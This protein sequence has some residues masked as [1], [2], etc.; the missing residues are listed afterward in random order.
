[1]RTWYFKRP[2]DKIT[3]SFDMPDDAHPLEIGADVDAIDL[4][5]MQFRRPDGE[6]RPIPRG[7]FRVV[8]AQTIDGYKPVYWHTTDEVA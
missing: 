7:A 2:E 6:W 1:M 3:I 8:R 5:K 4:E